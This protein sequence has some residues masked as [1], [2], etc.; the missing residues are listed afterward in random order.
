MQA[1]HLS[2]EFW[3]LSRSY[4]PIRENHRSFSVVIFGGVLGVTRESG[5]GLFEQQFAQCILMARRL[6]VHYWH[7]ISG[8]SYGCCLD[9]SIS[10]LCCIHL[11]LFAAPRSSQLSSQLPPGTLSYSIA[12][13]FQSNKLVYFSLLSFRSFSKCCP[14]AAQGTDTVP[15]SSNC[16]WRWLPYELP[17]GTREYPELEPPN[18]SICRVGAEYYSSSGWMKQQLF[19]LETWMSRLPYNRAF[20]TELLGST[21]CRNLSEAIVHP[22]VHITKGVD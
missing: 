8:G 16:Q 5:F 9:F 13:W 22:S 17:S 2:F 15:N 18:V 12:S 19:N 10:A 20:V 1:A 21:S 6:G 7:I 11:L 4:T 14:I 3:L